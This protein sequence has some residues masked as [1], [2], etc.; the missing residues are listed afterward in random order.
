[1]ADLQSQ[2]IF[3]TCN[4]KLSFTTKKHLRC[5]ITPLKISLVY[6]Q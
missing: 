4:T 5:Y 6:Y 1:M 2:Y 3:F